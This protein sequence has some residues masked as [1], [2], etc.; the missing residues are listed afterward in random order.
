MGKVYRH[1]GNR[2]KLAQSLPPR[3]LPLR[4]LSRLPTSQSIQPF[5]CPPWI[6]SQHLPHCRRQQNNLP[7]LR[8]ALQFP[9]LV[10][11]RLRHLA[12]RVSFAHPLSECPSCPSKGRSPRRLPQM[13]IAPPRKRKRT[14]KSL[15]YSPHFASSSPS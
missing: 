9:W 6:F 5:P 3:S 7:S 1:D 12:K 8:I 10:R 13:R 11:L 2:G 4:N 15:S 14:K